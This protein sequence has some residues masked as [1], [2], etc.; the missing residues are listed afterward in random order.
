MWQVLASHHNYNRCNVAMVE[1]HGKTSLIN[2]PG[3]VRSA[4][5]IRASGQEAFSIGQ[6]LGVYSRGS[7]VMYCNTHK[8]TLQK[9]LLFGQGSTQ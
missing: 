8:V 2:T 4:R 9:W 5:P 1:Y 7:I 6:R 3:G